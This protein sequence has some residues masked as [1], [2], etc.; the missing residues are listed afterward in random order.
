MKVTKIKF[1]LIAPQKGH[2]GFVSCVIDDWLFLN[3]IAVFTRL[4]D[5]NR[6][7]LVFPEKKINDNV[8]KMFYPLCSSSYFELEQII[9][10]KI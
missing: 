1:K 8:I 9:S 7:R 5:N 10:D 2:I 4:K 3:N 6:I